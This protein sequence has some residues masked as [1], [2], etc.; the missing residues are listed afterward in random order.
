[1]VGC[2]GGGP[3]ASVQVGNDPTC[4]RAGIERPD[5]HQR[6]NDVGAAPGDDRGIHGVVDRQRRERGGRVAHVDVVHEQEQANQ[7]S[8]LTEIA[9]GHT[10]RR[11]FAA[12]ESG[13]GRVSERLE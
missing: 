4:A 12:A 5:V 10:D 1:M 6:A 9:A 8:Q 7:R 2:G 13:V 11:R 3:H